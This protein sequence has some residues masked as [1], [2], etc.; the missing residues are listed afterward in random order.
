MV[1]EAGALHGVRVLVVD[2]DGD[3]RDVV[4]EFLERAGARV[5]TASSGRR[6]VTV[7]EA[8]EVDVVVTDINMDDGDGDWLL[9]EVRRRGPRTPV[10]AAGGRIDG[11]DAGR[12]RALGFAEALTKPLNGP[13]L[14]RAVARAA[15]RPL[16]GD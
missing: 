12:M 4:R 9:A 14:V 1:D 6:A 10:I 15:G 16:A 8:G 3:V 13:A 5:S 7:L 2:D 11:N